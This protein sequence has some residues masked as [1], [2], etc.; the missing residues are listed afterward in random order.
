MSAG[1]QAE[2]NSSAWFGFGS[3]Y[4]QL[5][6]NE[7][8]ITA[9]RKVTHPRGPNRTYNLAQNAPQRTPRELNVKAIDSS[10]NRPLYLCEMCGSQDP[11]ENHKR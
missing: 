1:N 2:P 5:G 10:K 11:K 4:E 8:A 6:E 3:I 7:A 9:Y